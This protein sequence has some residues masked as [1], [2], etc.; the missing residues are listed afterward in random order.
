VNWDCDVEQFDNAATVSAALHETVIGTGGELL[1]SG[2][3]N[4]RRLRRAW[5]RDD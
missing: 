3:D 5:L 2:N 1:L 4:R